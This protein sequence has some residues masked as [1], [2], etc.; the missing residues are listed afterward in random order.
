MKSGLCSQYNMSSM[1]QDGV[2]ELPGIN[3]DQLPT[4]HCL[5]ALSHLQ[6]LLVGSGL[7]CVAEKAPLST[8]T[9]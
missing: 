4:A 7:D 5:K 8:S 2:K 6:A 9:E 3:H 1:L